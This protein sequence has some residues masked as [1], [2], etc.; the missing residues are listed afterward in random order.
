MYEQFGTIRDAIYK[1][2]WDLGL[3]QLLGNYILRTKAGA[4]FDKRA[5]CQ[6]LLLSLL[7]ANRPWIGI[8]QNLDKLQRIFHDYDPDFLRSAKPSDLSYDVCAIGCGNRRIAK[9]M[10]EISYNIGILDDIEERFGDVDVPMQMAMDHP[11]EVLWVFSDKGSGYKFKGVAVALAAQYMKNLGVDLVKP[12]VH[13]R[14]FIQRIGWRG[15]LPDEYETISICK[16]IANKYDITQTEVGTIIWQYCATGYI[17][18]CDANPSCSSCPTFDNC[19]YGQ[20][21]YSG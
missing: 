9:Q 14:R 5:H 19:H 12:D 1:S 17:Q 2:G 10:E 7:S 20:N 11:K 8:E 15:Y 4:K 18:I 21:Y 6:A 13:L 3:E 16:E